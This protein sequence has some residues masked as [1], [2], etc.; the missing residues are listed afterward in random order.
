VK[1]SRHP[2]I[3][4]KRF[5]ADQRG[6]AMTETLLLALPLMMIAAALLQIFLIDEYTFRVAA[7]THQRLFAEQAFPANRPNVNFT[8]PTVRWDDPSPYVPVVGFF[9]PYGLTAD[10]LRIR[11][12]ARGGDKRMQIGR[13]TAPS[14]SPGGI[15]L[16][17][18]DSL[19]SVA[20][21]GL[22]RAKALRVELEQRARSG[23]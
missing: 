16:S 7:R 20:M 19:A 14:L 10:D 17:V 13:G 12:R 18:P 22:E 15:D 6:Q 9:A 3:A 2:I 5:A 8:T 1:R 11:S 21:T 23:R 4:G